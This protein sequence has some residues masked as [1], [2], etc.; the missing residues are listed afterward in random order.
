[1]FEGFRVKGNARM[2]LSRGEVIV[3]GE[4]HLGARA[5]GNS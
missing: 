1:M 4:R 5:V 3:D 2:V